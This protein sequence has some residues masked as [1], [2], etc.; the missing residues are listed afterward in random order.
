MAR[1]VQERASERTVPGAALLA[2]GA[3]STH[4]R[5]TKQL[6]IRESLVSGKADTPTVTVGSNAVAHVGD[7]SLSEAQQDA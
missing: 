2:A 6:D 7:P 1:Q 3:Q 5:G 4:G